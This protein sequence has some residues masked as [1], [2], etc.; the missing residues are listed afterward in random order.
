VC[1]SAGSCVCVSAG[2]CVCVS[3]GSRVYVRAGSYVCVCWV[4]M[5]MYASVLYVI[6]QHLALG[7]PRSFIIP[8]VDR[9][10]SDTYFKLN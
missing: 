8:S 10:M 1:E 3:A 9:A 5:Y 2:S 7:S 6:F 4:Y